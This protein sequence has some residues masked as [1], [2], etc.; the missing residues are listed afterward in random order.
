MSKVKNVKGRFRVDERKV[1]GPKYKKER[2][3]RLENQL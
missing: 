2:V 1:F 3:E